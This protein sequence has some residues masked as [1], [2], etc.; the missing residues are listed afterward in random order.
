MKISNN[1]VIVFAFSGL[2]AMVCSPLAMARGGRGGGGG[3]SFSG[4]GRSSAGSGSYGSVRQSSFQSSNNGFSGGQAS[5]DREATGP[6]GRTADASGGAFV[7]DGEAGVAR[8]ATGLEGRSA[9]GVA[10]AE[11]GDGQAS[12]VRAAAVSGERGSAAAVR[13]GDRVQT[14]PADCDRINWR[15]TAYYYYHGYCYH[16]IDEGDT[17]YYEVVEPPDGFIIYTLPDGTTTEVIDGVT[18]Y[19]CN[20]VYY[21]RTYTSGRVGYFVVAKPN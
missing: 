16:Q 3:R 19:I 6:G 2:L 1:A 15:G 12:G 11:W 9:A 10:G 17:Y 21:R 20:G 8:Q 5:W 4:G 18:Y 13:W 7:G 14:L